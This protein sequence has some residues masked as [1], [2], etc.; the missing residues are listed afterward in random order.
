MSGTVEKTISS[1][2]LL[3]SIE[4]VRLDPWQFA[5]AAA[6]GFA[7]VIA[8]AWMPAAE[9]SRIN[10]ISSLSLAIHTE[11]HP[12]RRRSW[13]WWAISCQAVAVIL[14]IVALRNGPPLLA[15][16]GAFF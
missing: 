3:V 9:A 2:Y 10:P 14:C 6:F 7:A 5:V 13:Q 8:G 15:F 1:L 11:A 12:R 4:H 16:G